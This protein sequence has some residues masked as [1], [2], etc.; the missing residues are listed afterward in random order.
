MWEQA[1]ITFSESAPFHNL[2]HLH[3]FNWLVQI[4]A[5]N[6]LIP[7]RKD[8]VSHVVR[9]SPRDNPKSAS[10]VPSSWNIKNPLESNNNM[11]SS[12]VFS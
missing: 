4:F 7:S 9:D 5:I 6:L 10:F 1:A 8:V 2:L 11:I 3:F 12:K